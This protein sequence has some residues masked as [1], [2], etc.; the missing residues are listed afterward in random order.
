MNEITR[1]IQKYRDFIHAPF[2]WYK[3]WNDR[4]RKCNITTRKTI[5]WHR[6]GHRGRISASA[7]KKAFQVRQQAGGVPIYGRLTLSALEAKF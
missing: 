7:S 6:F 1:F 3:F 5:L 2:E 4:S